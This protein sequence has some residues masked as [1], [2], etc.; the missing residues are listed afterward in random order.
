MAQLVYD[1]YF[2]GPEPPVQP[3]LR[4]VEGDGLVKLYW[5]NVAEDSE[6][7]L[8]GDK[9]FVGYK[10]YKS[11][12]FGASWG[13][14]TFNSDG[15]RG[16]NYIPL[17]EFRVDESTGLIQHTFI[18]SNLTNGFEYWYAVT[19]Y[20]EGDESIPLDPL[21]SGKGRPGEDSSAVRATPRTYP[22]GY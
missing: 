5:S 6:D 11:S 22:A 17:A 7:P 12:N 14:L 19:A 3:G 1:N 15:S 10:I 21:E 4:A 18:D 13:E 9:D 20:D 16:P 2:A 8:S